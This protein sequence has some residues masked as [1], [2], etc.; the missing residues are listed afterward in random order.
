MAGS[1]EKPV[2][3]EASGASARNKVADRWKNIDYKKL[4]EDIAGADNGIKAERSSTKLKKDKNQGEDD[5]V[6]IDSDSET[7]SQSDTDTEVLIVKESVPSSSSVRDRKLHDTGKVKVDSI[8]YESDYCFKLIK[9][10]VFDT[11]YETLSNDQKSHFIT[12]DDIFNDPML[13]ST[14]L[15][16]YQYNMDYLLS[17]FH[18]NLDDIT[19]VMQTG[20]ILPL[21]KDAPDA[22]HLLNNRIKFVEIDMPPYS[23]HHSKMILNFYSDKSMRIFI[24]SNNFTEAEIT[25]PQQVCWC[26]PKLRT[27]TD[28]N[29]AKKS[30]RISFLN[31]LVEY[32]FRYPQDH[33]TKRLVNNI[34]N[35]DFSLLG[36]LHFLFSTP[37]RF[38]RMCTIEDKQGDD[39]QSGLIKFASAV[40]DI[41][42]KFTEKNRN[43]QIH[44]LVQTSSIG[45]KILQRK[46]MFT[47]Y[48]IPELSNTVTYSNNIHGHILYPTLQEVCNSPASLL[49][50]GWFHFN[51]D[52]SSEPYKSMKQKKIFVKQ[53]PIATSL[54]RRATPSHSKFYMKWTSKDENDVSVP[55]DSVDWCLYTS[56]NLSNAAWGTNRTNATNFEVGILIPGPIKIFSFVDLIYKA[57]EGTR[58]GNSEDQGSQ[59]TR[60]VTKSAVI[61]PFPKSLVLYSGND[62]PTNVKLLDRIRDTALRL[63]QEEDA[64]R[65]SGN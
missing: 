19:I 54:Q 61:V 11:N 53:D 64:V 47:G 42:K 26:S 2:R 32:I 24:P 35:H 55:K 9:S 39:E 52:E 46:H 12:M 51:Y 20:C 33:F 15:F 10:T 58:L 62:K 4:G 27:L 23:S 21:S 65:G 40:H 37:K 57:T 18:P 43:E 36:G 3:N 45:T 44:Y 7:G 28:E 6:V 22:L 59:I 49:S 8:L 50:G 17:C 14:V 60:D 1:I 29:I 16:S 13:S 25:Y 31:E 30:N 63:Q 56:G 5:V 48:M 34:K 38:R 41:E